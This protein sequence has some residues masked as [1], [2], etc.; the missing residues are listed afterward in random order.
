LLVEAGAGVLLE[1]IS[2]DVELILGG[3]GGIGD[4]GFIG[5][6][7]VCTNKPPLFCNISVHKSLKTSFFKGILKVFQRYI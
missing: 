5:G 1:E 7:G 3:V 4:K 6:V 2:E